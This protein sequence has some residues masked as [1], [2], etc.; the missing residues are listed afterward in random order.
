MRKKRSFS[1]SLAWAGITNIDVGGVRGVVKAEQMFAKERYFRP[2][3]EE[4]FVYVR[5]LGTSIARFIGVCLACL[6]HLRP[7]FVFSSCFCTS[8]LVSHIVAPVL[9]TL[10]NT[11]A[12]VSWRCWAHSRTHARMRTRAH[13][14]VHAQ[15]HAR[16]HE[17]THVRVHICARTICT[18]ICVVDSSLTVS[19]QYP[20]SI[21]T[22]SSW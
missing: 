3:R 4:S 21:L 14:H 7:I 8:S 12:M 22:V 17:R 9:R 2:G 1:S 19:S 11:G 10:R 13:V 5:A 16:V 18:H 20:H 15:T 6:A